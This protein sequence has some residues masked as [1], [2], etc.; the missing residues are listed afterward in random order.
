PPGPGGPGR[1]RPRFTG[2]QKAGGGG[3]QVGVAAGTKLEHPHARRGVRHEDMQ[4]PV[5]AARSR[6][7]ELRALA[8][9]V[10]HRLPPASSHPNYLALHSSRIIGAVLALGGRPPWTPPASRRAR[11]PPP[12]HPPPPPPAPPPPPP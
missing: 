10:P 4:Q 3:E 5:A 9:D 11:S 12:P 1:S 2:G 7:G 8:G 6:P